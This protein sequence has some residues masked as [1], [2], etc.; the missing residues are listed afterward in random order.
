MRI[1]T[2]VWVDLEGEWNARSKTEAGE[3]PFKETKIARR[4]DRSG[5][6]YLPQVW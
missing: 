6:E 3:I 2:R 5:D 1:L 4:P